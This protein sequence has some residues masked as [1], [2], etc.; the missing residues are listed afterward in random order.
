M[1]RLG[2]IRKSELIDSVGLVAI[3]NCIVCR[4]EIGVATIG[5]ASLRGADDTLK[6]PKWEEARPEDKAAVTSKL[7]EGTD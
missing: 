5:A 1:C 7:C 4:L 3:S 6:V 2:S